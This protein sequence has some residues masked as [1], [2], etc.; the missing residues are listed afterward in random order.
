MHYKVPDNF[1]K[2]DMNKPFLKGSCDH[3]FY[4]THFIQWMN[5]AIYYI[6]LYYI[7]LMLMYS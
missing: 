4:K 3:F 6:I 7:G 2:F 5:N 1:K